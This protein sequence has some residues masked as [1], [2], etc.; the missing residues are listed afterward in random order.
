MI[1]NEFKKVKGDFELMHSFLKQMANVSIYYEFILFI[2]ENPYPFSNTKEGDHHHIEC[3][4][5]K[6]KG[7]SMDPDIEKSSNIIQLTPTLYLFAHIL[8]AARVGYCDDIISLNL[9]TE[10]KKK[11]KRLLFNSKS[12]E[13]K[14]AILSK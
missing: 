5:M 2:W 13:R 9:W 7:L 10:G 1:I 11:K 12:I 14:N 4:Y 6:S 8:R 3:K